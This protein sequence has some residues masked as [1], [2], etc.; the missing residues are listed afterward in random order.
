M[1][2]RHLWV[3]VRHVYMDPGHYLETLHT[4]FPRSLRL[5]AKE[6]MT[7]SAR[8]SGGYQ[9]Q[10]AST[11]RLTPGPPPLWSVAQYLRYRTRTHTPK[12]PHS[13][14]GSRAAP[15]RFRFVGI[16]PCVCRPRRRHHKARA[17]TPIVGGHLAVRPC[18]LRVKLAGT[19][20]P[21]DD[22]TRARGV[23]WTHGEAATI[24]VSARAL[25]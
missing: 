25:W 3:R 4:N 13:R 23:R 10:A 1:P 18:R 24:G 16:I 12:H 11:L 14:P 9:E 8:K 15:G 22:G 6:M 5:T 17:D 21:G 19:A 20:G 2:E 7:A